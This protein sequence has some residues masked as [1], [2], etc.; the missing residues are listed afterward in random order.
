MRKNAA[1]GFQQGCLSTAVGTDDTG[2]SSGGDGEENVVQNGLFAIAGGQMLYLEKAHTL[3][4][5]RTMR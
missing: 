5:P 2:Q 1:D 3:R 4:L